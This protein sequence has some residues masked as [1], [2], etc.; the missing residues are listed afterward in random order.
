MDDGLLPGSIDHSDGLTHSLESHILKVRSI[1]QQL[2]P[3]V[4][5]VYITAADGTSKL[6]NADGFVK[7]N[8]RRLPATSC[9][10]QAR[11]ESVIDED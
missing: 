1:L 11:Y 2:M 7:T 3:I 4:D 6:Q 10:H 8:G 9:L 5:A